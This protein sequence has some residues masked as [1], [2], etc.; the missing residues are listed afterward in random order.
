MIMVATQNFCPIC[1]RTVRK[2]QTDNYPY[3]KVRCAESG[4][5]LKEVGIDP[6]KEDWTK[7]LRKEG[8]EYLSQH[9]SL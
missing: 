7:H 9:N 4:M 5:L 6:E 1:R 3:C 8:R 2:D